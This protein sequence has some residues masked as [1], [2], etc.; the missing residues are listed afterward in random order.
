MLDKLKSKKIV[1][2]I[3]VVLAMGMNF[4]LVFNDSVWFD[5]SFTMLTLKSGFRDI[6]QITIEDVHPPLY[7]LILKCITL[8][9][10]YSV[11]VAK[12]ASLIPVFLA[13]VLGITFITRR[14]P[15]TG[16][17]NFYAAIL[18][19]CFLSAMP[20][21]L[22]E[23]LEVRM[24]TW[25]MLFVTATG[26]YAF[27]AYFNPKRKKNWIILSITALAAAYTHYFGLVAVAAVYLLL[28]FALIIK[29][30]KVASCLISGVVCGIG[31]LLWLPFL[32]KQINLVK[33]GYWIP[34]ITLDKL[35]EYVLWLFQGE[36]QNVWLF[37]LTLAVALLIDNLL[38]RNDISNDT[39]EVTFSMLAFF[40]VFAGTILLGCILSIIMR[41]ILVERYLFVC[42]GLLYIF[43]SYS[44]TYFI[45][46]R[47]VKIG[48]L[49]IVIL[50]GLF[51]YS[52]KFDNEYRNGTEE[53]KQIFAENIS[54]ADLVAT[55]DFLLGAHNGSPLLYYLPDNELVTIENEEQIPLI[56]GYEKTWYFATNTFNQEMFLNQGYSVTYIYQGTIDVK[57][58]YTLYLIQKCD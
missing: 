1:L 26:V 47:K 34:E 17:K 41:P 39:K 13:M 2:I 3:V 19:I 23:N 46:N 45:N 24:Y 8:V 30:K 50:T 38:H 29:R 36:F 52:A 18:F 12:V 28:F 56:E 35:L 31:Y 4:S 10:G 11:P 51:A 57:H 27:E 40:L 42:I 53:S 20:S 15:N 7:Y 5:E 43:L 25:T 22:E 6:I 44:L 55:N 9:L 33:E 37:I 58:P 32:W 14:F 49:T 48:V 16:N 21:S 54:S